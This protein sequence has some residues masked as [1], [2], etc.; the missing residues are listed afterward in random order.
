[1]VFE[2]LKITGKVAHGLFTFIFEIGNILVDYLVNGLTL[3][4]AVITV[5]IISALLT[6]DCFT[7]QAGCRDSILGH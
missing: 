1:V 4:V 2:F 7:I 5:A 3:I 6:L